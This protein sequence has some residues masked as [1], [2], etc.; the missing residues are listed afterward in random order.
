MSVSVDQILQR[1]ITDACNMDPNLIGKITQ[2]TSIYIRFATAASAI[3]GLYKQLDWTVD[4]IFPSTMSKE[5]LEKFATERGKDVSEMTGADILEF[6]IQYLRKPPSGGKS[7]DYERWALETVSNGS[8]IEMEA[9][10]VNTSGSTIAVNASNLITPKNIDTIG[11]EVGSTDV[12]KYVIIDFGSSKNVFG[13]GLGFT[14]KRAAEF[15]VYSSTDGTSWTK[16]GTVGAAKW[17]MDDFDA[18]DAQYWKIVLKSIGSLESWQTASLN[19]VKCYGIEFYT[20]ED[21]HESA[22]Y[23]K[24]IANGK[25]VGTMSILLA[26]VSL[27]MRLIENVRKHCEEEGPVAPREIFVSVQ[28]EST[29]D[30]Y[31]N[32]A[33]FGNLD[34]TAFRSDV[35][36]YFDS[37]QAGDIFVKAQIIVFAIKHGASNATVTYTVNGGTSLSADSYKPSPE[38]KLVLGALTE[39]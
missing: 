18:V 35:E 10:M 19:T 26:P 25:G 28:S 31:V 17:S 36:K 6:V 37:L 1:M 38:E 34:E 4:Q 3:W 30:L 29:I 13:I 23:A 2:G 11:F 20:E 16:Q 32:V 33:E 39:V 8:V 9:S 24:T 15:D 5:S 27:S 7:S 22:D 21:S 14:T 12:N